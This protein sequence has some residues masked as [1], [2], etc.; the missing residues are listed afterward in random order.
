MS[1]DHGDNWSPTYTS[2]PL[3]TVNM[4][5]IIPHRFNHPMKQATLETND[6]P[7]SGNESQD[8]QL[9]T[10][11][12]DCWDFASRT[13]PQILSAGRS[14]S[15]ARSLVSGPYGY[16]DEQRSPTSFEDLSYP[17]HLQDSLV[18]SPQNFVDNSSQNSIYGSQSQHI[19]VYPTSGLRPQAASWSIPR[20]YESGH[21]S[22]AYYAG[23][24]QMT[25]SSITNM[26]H[27][28]TFMLTPVEPPQYILPYASSE[29]DS[30]LFTPTTVC[31]PHMPL[32]NMQH[33]SYSSGAWPHHQRPN[34]VPLS[35]NDMTTAQLQSEYPAWPPLLSPV[36]TPA[37]YDNLGNQMQPDYGFVFDPEDLHL[38]PNRTT[39]HEAMP[40]R[41]LTY[42]PTSNYSGV[43][44]VLHSSVPKSQA[45]KVTA[46]SGLRSEPDLFKVPLISPIVFSSVP[47]PVTTSFSPKSA[48]S[49]LDSPI[50]M[51]IK[52]EEDIVLSCYC[53]KPHDADMVECLGPTHY[54]PRSFHLG[55]A[56]LDTPPSGIYIGASRKPS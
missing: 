49:T 38:L 35:V 6:D 24:T 7:L 56:G 17:A 36:A 13:S 52:Q 54:H 39:F 4:A 44:S 21:V 20:H 5:A 41:M 3:G 9:G 11:D 16:P 19:S 51:K 32:A 2:P 34:Y 48:M 15:G 14:A 47:S 25:S 33:D 50:K 40:E 43:S 10:G 42:S 31:N 30:Y 45:A 18:S 28:S 46:S 53:Q 29:W 26:P 12:N 55:C 27:H 23:Q 37:H 1:F 8:S 22:S